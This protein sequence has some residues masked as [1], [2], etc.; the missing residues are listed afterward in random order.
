[1]SV[2]LCSRFRDQIILAGKLGC[3]VYKVYELILE[4]EAPGSRLKQAAKLAARFDELSSK[5]EAIGTRIA[6]LESSV[7]S[8]KML[9]DLTNELSI[10]RK[11]VE[12]LKG[13]FSRRINRIAESID[14]IHLSA[15]WRLRDDHNGCKWLSKYGYCTCL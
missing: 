12:D 3:S 11:E 13:R 1:M 4:Q 9:K 8:L 14:F 6:S 7:S 10:V 2:E 5:V 15:K